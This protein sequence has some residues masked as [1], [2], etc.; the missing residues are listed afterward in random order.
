MFNE[1][2]KKLRKEAGLTQ[3]EV[4]DIIGISD[5]VY[6]YYE[7]ERFPKDEKIIRKLTVC[8]DCT[9]DYLFG[10]SKFRNYNEIKNIHETIEMLKLIENPIIL[11]D[12]KNIFNTLIDI[13][14]YFEGNSHATTSCLKTVVDSIHEIYSSYRLS[15]EEPEDSQNLKFLEFKAFSIDKIDAVNEYIKAMANDLANRIKE[16][17]E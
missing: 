8:F 6:A 11:E 14:R 10:L 2:L 12:V 13:N 16:G 4:A 1:R 5:R 3:K 17:L 9:A 7:T 15:I